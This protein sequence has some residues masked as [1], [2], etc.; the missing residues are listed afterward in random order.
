[1]V[2]DEPKRTAE[3]NIIHR[4]CGYT[5]V[6]LYMRTS[7]VDFLITA[8]QSLENTYNSSYHTLRL[9]LLTA[10]LWH[11]RGMNLT[12]SSVLKEHLE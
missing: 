2:P 11:P 4:Y 3:M 6:W 9:F 5:M 8:C 7:M 1:M 10:Y 12:S